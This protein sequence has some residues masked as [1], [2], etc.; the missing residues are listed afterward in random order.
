MGIIQILLVQRCVGSDG[1]L[2][3]KGRGGCAEGD[4]TRLQRHR[5]IELRACRFGI[6]RVGERI[7]PSH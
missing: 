5:R 2:L 1:R 4:Q 6:E 7:T 3:P